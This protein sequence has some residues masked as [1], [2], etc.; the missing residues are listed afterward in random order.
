MK[1]VFLLFPLLCMS[2]CF[3]ACDDDDDDDATAVEEEEVSEDIRILTFEDE[4]YLGSGFATGETWSDLID[5]AEYY[6]TQL[7]GDLAS[8]YSFYDEGNTELAWDGLIESWGSVAFWNFGYAV[9]NYWL[10]DVSTASYLNQLSVSTTQN[11]GPGADGS[12]NFLVVYCYRSDVDT[13]TSANPLYFAD[14][15]A[16]EPQYV[17]VTNTAYALNSLLGYDSYSTA[18]T[19]ETEFTLYAEGVQE[20]GTIVRTS[21][22]LA[23][24]TDLLTEWTE[25]DLTPLGAV[26]ELRFFVMGSDDLCGDWGL[27]TPGYAAL[28]NL[29][30]K[31]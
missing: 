5:D 21:I 14:G 2:L 20:D 11:P 31:F 26:T 10:E 29:A 15:L 7:Y 18:A 1:K 3:V 22:L 17:Y 8:E 30:V 19:D 24:G 28:D 27:N 6:G 9:S 4:D 16:H 23:D 25:F 13:Q 12:D